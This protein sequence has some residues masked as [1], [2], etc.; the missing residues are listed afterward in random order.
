MNSLWLLIQLH[1]F[2]QYIV[3]LLSHLSLPLLLLAHLQVVESG[4]AEATQKEL[5]RGVYRSGGPCRQK[6]SCTRC[7]G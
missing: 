5:A 7:A 3:E 6:K 4:S 2:F 1:L